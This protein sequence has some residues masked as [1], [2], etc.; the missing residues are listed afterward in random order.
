[1]KFPKIYTF[2]ATAKIL[3]LTRQA[4]N[5]RMQRGLIVESFPVYGSRFRVITENELERL[6]KVVVPGV[7]MEMARR[8][9]KKCS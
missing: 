1:M 6:K 8:R 9:R 4:F 5:E 3:G 7:S 2:K